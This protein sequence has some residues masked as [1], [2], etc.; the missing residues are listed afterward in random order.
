MKV[1]KVDENISI[2]QYLEKIRP[3]LGKMMDEHL[4]MKVKFMPSKENDDK[5][6]IH[7]K[8]DNVKIMIGNETD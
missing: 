5:K 2:E 4:T 7:S 8:S 6:S 1:D 3:Y